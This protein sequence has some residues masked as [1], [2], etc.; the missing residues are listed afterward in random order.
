MLQIITWFCRVLF[1]LMAGLMTFPAHANGA[2]MIQAIDAT[3]ANVIFMRHALAPGFG[4]PQDFKV[5][6]CATQRNLDATGRAQARK[7]GATIR[8]A[9]VHVDRVLSSQWCR[10]LETAELLEL[11][12]VTPFAGLNS[13]FQGHANRE[14]TLAL[15]SQHLSDLDD[16]L[17][18]MVTHQVV[19]SAVTGFSVGSG[20][21]VAFNTRTGAAQVFALD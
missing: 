15:L 3:N 17:T 19:I 6:N 18:L 14:T 8:N 9:D 10:C 4:D 2:P 7:I 21:F 5:E 20:Q 16:G 13:F 1:M 11:G 12:N